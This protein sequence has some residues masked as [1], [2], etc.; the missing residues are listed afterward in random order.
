MV[1]TKKGKRSP[2]KFT[3]DSYVG[4]QKAWHTIAMVNATQFA[5]LVLQGYQNDGTPLSTSSQLFTRLDFIRQNN[6]KGT[7]WQ[8]EVMQSGFMQNHSLNMASGNEQNRFRLSGTCFSQDG[9]V[10]NSS[11]KKYFINFSNDLTINKWLSAGVSGT[12]SHFEKNYYNS[13]LYGG[14]LTTA[15][16]ADTLTPA[17]DKITNNWAGQIFPTPTT[18]QEV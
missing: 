3:L 12:F 8:D 14:V 17:W 7:N 1:T 15:L 2:V 18:L 9:I 16:A 13:D 11:M 10:R 5:D 4:N 6:Y